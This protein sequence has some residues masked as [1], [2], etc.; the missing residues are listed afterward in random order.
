MKNTKKYKKKR[1]G[2]YPS[3]NVI[4]SIS[5]ALFVIGLFGILFLHTAKLTSI[6]RENIE[7]QVYLN[8]NIS[9]SQKIT[10]QQTL[11]TKPYVL[12]KE[13]EAQINYIPKDE[14]AQI[15]L[16]ETGEDIKKV[17]ADNPLRDAFTLKINEGYYEQ[18][19][20]QQIKSEIEELRGVF[21][22]VYVESLINSIN[23][24]LTKISL[25]LLIFATIL[26]LVVIIL[27]NNTIKLAL[28][29]Q[30]FL[31]RSMQ[32]VGATSGFIRKPFLYRSSVYGLFGG[33]IAS[34]LLFGL[35]QYAYARIEDLQLLQDFN[36][37]IIMFGFLLI[38]GIIIGFF[39]TYRAINKYLKM[40]LD[41]LY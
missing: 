1:L 21:E 31:I 39:S 14:A 3:A 10:L 22:V 9:E 5:L 16:N 41:D 35:L 6:I 40:S 19:K 11:A 7:I 13:N 2:S 29:S 33:I 37:L 15:F 34:A 17:L 4:F 30:R 32:L 26:L 23:K 28:F 12:S 24:N 36:N 27:I 20:L 18:Q 38:G 25:V 8:N